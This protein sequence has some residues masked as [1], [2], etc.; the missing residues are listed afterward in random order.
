MDSN[1][2]TTINLDLTI[3]MTEIALFVA[4]LNIKTP[5]KMFRRLESVQSYIFSC[6]L[7][8]TYGQILDA[9]PQS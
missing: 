6:A 7:G 3:S 5:E 4:I 9:V 8:Y 2:T 1:Q